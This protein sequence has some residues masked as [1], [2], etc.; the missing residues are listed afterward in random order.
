[1]TVGFLTFVDI[2]LELDPGHSAVW[3]LPHWFVSHT[4][5]RLRNGCV[6]LFGFGTVGQLLMA[7]ATQDD[8]SILVIHIF[9]LN[10]QENLPAFLLIHTFLYAVSTNVHIFQC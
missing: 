8:L 5:S 4:L 2:Q 10:P 6:S 1:M 3:E 7:Q 9:F